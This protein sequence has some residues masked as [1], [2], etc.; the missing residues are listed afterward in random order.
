MNSP[1]L[2]EKTV[3]DSIS[4]YCD[5]EIFNLHIMYIFVKSEMFVYIYFK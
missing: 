5:S 1:I 2:N 4:K 3:S